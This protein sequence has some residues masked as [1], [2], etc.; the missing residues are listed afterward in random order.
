[1]SLGAFWGVA[2]SFLTQPV[3]L[4]VVAFSGRDASKFQATI[5]KIY[6]PNRLLAGAIVGGS[7]V[8]KTKMWES[9]LLLDRFPSDLQTTAFLCESYSCQLP[10]S[11]PEEL[12]EQ[13]L[14]SVPQGKFS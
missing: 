11:K 13:I 12:K 5:G 1:M 10:V 14:A 7:L 6:L 4:A 2:H 3:E 9:P 8:P